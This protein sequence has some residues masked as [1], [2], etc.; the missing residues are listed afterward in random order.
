MSYHNNRIPKIIHLLCK[1]KIIPKH[2]LVHLNRIKELHPGWQINICDDE[3]MD[4]IVQEH[5]PEYWKMFHSFP[6]H[7]QRLDVF[8]IMIVYLHGGFYLD[9]DMHC[10]KPLDPLL[11]N[12]LVLGEEKTLSDFELKETHHKHALRIGNYMFGSVQKHSF[13]LEF[14]QTALNNCTQQILT[15]NDILETTGPGLLTN[16]YHNYAQ[17][18]KDITLLTNK[19]ARCLKACSTAASCH[20]GDYAAHLHYGSWR[21]QHNKVS[22]HGYT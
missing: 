22:E 7:I 14:M 17:A 3:D 12:M 1:D 8:R 21:W 9:M 10:Y 16:F 5:F 19:T 11:N 15:E 13:L 18:H 4:K 6:V 20:F 2:Y